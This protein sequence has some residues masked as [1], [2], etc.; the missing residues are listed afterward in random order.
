MDNITNPKREFAAAIPDVVQAPAITTP[1]ITGV[2]PEATSIASWQAPAQPRTEFNNV[3]PPDRSPEATYWQT[4]KA[5]WR[6]SKVAQIMD[7]DP[8]FYQIDPSFKPYESVRAWEKVN[9]TTLTP[10]EDAVV[11]RAKN[12][13]DYQHRL[14]RVMAQRAD[15]AQMAANPKVAMG[16]AFLSPDT[17]ALMAVTGPA[18]A[19]AKTAQITSFAGRASVVGGV[20]A[21]TDLA[22]VAGA[23]QVQKV[24]NSSDY[25]F[26]IVAGMLGVPIEWALNGGA[27]GLVNARRA[28]RSTAATEATTAL[29]NAAAAIE[30]LPPVSRSVTQGVNPETATPT[31]TLAAG[32]IDNAHV[33]METAAANKT[34]AVQA[35]SMTPELED[36]LLGATRDYKAMLDGSY[37][38]YETESIAKNYDQQAAYANK[39]ALTAEEAYMDSGDVSAGNAA[40]TARA[41]EQ[42]YATLA[43][44]IRDHADSIE[45]NAHID[46]QREAAST[47]VGFK[48]GLAII[49]AASSKAIKDRD[50]LTNIANQV[51]RSAKGKSSSLDTTTPVGKLAM[52]AGDTAVVRTFND[53]LENMF[54]SGVSRMLLGK[55]AASDYSGAFQT[56]AMHI[57]AGRVPLNEWDKAVGEIVGKRP[58]FG[59]QAW[60]N[61]RLAIEGETQQ[62][63]GQLRKHTIIDGLPESSFNKSLYS[64]EAIEL[65]DRYVQT[66]FAQQRLKSLQEHR[67]SGA[68][69]IKPSAHYA[70][71][72][73]H[74]DRLRALEYIGQAT[75]L[76]IYDY[77]GRLMLDA[78]PAIMDSAHGFKYSGKVATPEQFIG[79]EFYQQLSGAKADDAIRLTD[80]AIAKL[81]KQLQTSAEAITTAVGEVQKD[82]VGFATRG[83]TK[84]RTE[85]SWDITDSSGNISLKDIIDPDLSMGLQ[86]Y[87]AKTAGDIGM[88]KAGMFDENSFDTW[89]DSMILEG[90]ANN[91]KAGDI[92][93]ASVEEQRAVLQMAKD[94]VYHRGLGEKQGPMLSMLTNLGGAS[95]LKFSGLWGIGE[96]ANLITF[97]GAADTTAAMLRELG[98][99]IRLTSRTDASDMYRFLTTN[100]EAS[101]TVRNVL[102]Q[103]ADNHFGQNV[104]YEGWVAHKQQSVQNL[105]LGNH[106]QRLMHNTYAH[107]WEDHITALGNM[108][109]RGNAKS[110]DYFRYLVESSHG[111]GTKESEA[112][113]KSFVDN[114]KKYGANTN[115]WPTDVDEQLKTIL[116][117]EMDNSVLAT[118]AADMPRW[119]SDSSAAKIIVP[120]LTFQANT[121]A[122]ITR[123]A[124][125]KEGA[126]AVAK[127]IAVSAAYTAM[128]AGTKNVINGKP[129]EDKLVVSTASQISAFGLPNAFAGMGAQMLFP[130]A[131]GNFSPSAAAFAGP[132]SIAAVMRS[133]GQDDADLGSVTTAASKLPYVGVFWGTNLLRAALTDSKE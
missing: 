90:K 97:H 52:W 40:L 41:E 105:N 29:D 62:Y 100:A 15:K 131:A 66:G 107:L 59:A 9:G 93:P 115:S 10:D 18:G 53:E 95:M 98:P 108:A 124:H 111:V 120:F 133:L 88:T 132:K 118:S 14:D 37:I 43:Q 75:R 125:H 92:N 8:K 51:E 68:A 117:A 82:S 129:F 48:E 69:E 80:V 34:A 44:G 32:S 13:D 96:A 17:I 122:K 11:L 74:F 55:T 113:M 72:R 35:G 26:S 70:P 91:V 16:A 87:N 109:H 128:I 28:A 24:T 1:E 84:Q 58:F 130:E 12:T 5:A 64:A 102:S 71:Q 61:S 78:N 56:T 3:T 77:L 57:S 103:R 114:S 89:A 33:R 46:A 30:P 47:L 54:G 112:V 4:T 116:L 45:F 73:I 65:G 42:R 76:G 67:V 25:A 39:R 2:Y 121:L 19:L 127:F 126:A 31:V 22:M 101:R 7:Y 38:R 23:E 110:T 123:R 79:R 27:R 6:D 85:F 94:I 21:T 83:Y 20:M 60:E 36:E 99:S 49:T 106:V 86:H 50:L 119:M 81:S 63:L 104:G